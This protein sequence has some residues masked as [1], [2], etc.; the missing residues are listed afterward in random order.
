[1]DDHGG[2]RGRDDRTG[3]RVKDCSDREFTGDGE[4][5]DP[6]FSSCDLRGGRGYRRGCELRE[7]PRLLKPFSAL[8]LR[9]HL[10]PRR[11]SGCHAGAGQWTRPKPESGAVDV[12]IAASVRGC[13]MGRAV[14]TYENEGE[15]VRLMSQRVVG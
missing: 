13:G 6:A 9:F 10:V 12:G 8:D 2:L 11:T 7:L 1:M 14:T 15:R 5:S 3:Q 4:E